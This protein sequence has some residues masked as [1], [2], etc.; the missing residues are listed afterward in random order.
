MMDRA[1][2]TN[3]AKRS[4]LRLA[5]AATPFLIVWGLFE[6]QVSYG[7]LRYV[8]PIARYV[9]IATT[10]V[11]VLDLL[12][13]RRKLSD[14]P[15]PAF[16]L[17]DRKTV[18]ITTAS[19][20]AALCL[21]VLLINWANGGTQDVSAIGGVLPYSDATG[22]FEG[23]EHLI[24]DGHLTPWNERRPLNAAFLAA[25]LILTGNNFFVALIIQALLAAVALFLATSALFQTHGKTTAL[26][27][28]AFSFAFVSC[29]LHRTL[30]EPLGISLGLIAFALLWSGVANK[31][32]TQYALGIFVLSLALLARAGAMF[33]L[34]ASVLFAAFFFSATWRKRLVGVLAALSAIGVAWFINHAI[35]QFYGTANGALLSNFSYTLYGL[36]QG[37]TSWAQGLADFPQLTGADDAKIASFLYQKAIEAILTK[38]YLLIW[39]LTKSLA[40]GIATFPGHIFRLLADGSDGGSHWRQIHMVIAA[41]LMLPLLGLGIFKLLQRPRN[42]LDRF[43]YFLIVQLLAFVCSL[44]FFYLDGGIRL[45]AATFP[46]TAAT[47]AFILAALT[48]SRRVPENAVVTQK[49]AIAAF[50]TAAIVV[51]LALSAPRI[52]QLI[53]PA[54]VTTAGQCEAGEEGLQIRIGDGSARINIV[55]D[56]RQPSVAPNI[57]QIDFAV[58]EANEGKQEWRSISAPATILMAFDLKSQSLRQIIG[59]LGFADGTSR[60]AAL[61][62]LPL[63]GQVF[64]HR[65]TPKQ[66]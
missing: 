11:V 9:I 55:S 50:S 42:K 26:L 35:V 29:C 47:M 65:V 62:A 44:P 56:L 57:R 64:T 52:H 18:A 28:F 63:R 8:D 51:L 59:P 49:I 6:L 45:T 16:A 1:L 54:A 60:L 32:L 5:F 23:A 31:S 36:S 24:Y 61:C 13:T 10:A 40:L 58:P 38:P 19:S 33:A 53:K 20:I 3:S 12:R 48:P 34:P 30:S 2:G 46:L 43:H 7:L 14:Q 66:R 25:R 27:F 21:L 15:A 37:G 39:G 41:A 22:Y 4:M 17:F